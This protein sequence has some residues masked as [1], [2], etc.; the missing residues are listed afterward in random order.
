MTKRILNSVFILGVLIF[1]VGIFG[2]S[3]SKTENEAARSEELGLSLLSEEETVDIVKDGSSDYVILFSQGDTM[4][5]DTELA[6]ELSTLIRR[7]YGVTVRYKPD[8]STDESECEILLGLTTRQLSRDLAEAIDGIG[9]EGEYVWVIAERDGKLAFLANSS[10]AFE[11]GKEEFLSYLTED[12]FS[13][14]RGLFS[15]GHITLDEIEAENAA[16]REKELERLK[17]INAENFSEELFGKASYKP[18]IA[19]NGAHYV[20]SPYDKPWFYPTVGQHPRYL[21][22]G[23]NIDRIKEML[24]D[25]T[26]ANL[27]KAFWELANAGEDEHFFGVFPEVKGKTGT[28]R[29]DSRILAIIDAK[30]LAY[31]ITG[32]E[33][34]A[35][36]AI[37]SI[38]NAALT[39]KFTTDIHGD[40][41]HGPSHVMV[42]MAAVYDWCYDVLTE[43]DKWQMIYCVATKLAAGL[44][45]GMQYPPSGMN[46]VCGHG[47]GPQFVRDWMTVAMV[48]ADEVPDWWEFVG[49]RYFEE[50]L[51]VAN[52]QFENGWVSQGTAIYGQ[53]KI[54]AQAWAAYLI[55]TSV[56]ENC[57][58]EDARLTMYYEM[59]HIASNDMYFQTGDGSRNSVGS[60][61]GF[62]EYFVVA[63]LYNDP[64]IY[65]H[66]RRYSKDHTVFFFEEAGYD[67]ILT[68]TPAFQLCFTS[69]VDY[70]G[71]DARDGVDVIQY[72]ADPAGQMTVREAWDDE[73]SITVFMKIGNET[74]SNHDVNDHGTF[75]IYYKGLL[76]ATS[77]AYNGYGMPSH[78]YYHQATIAH[79]GLLIFNPA[80][81]DAEPDY[82][83]TLPVT[84]RL[85]NASRYYYSGSQD[86]RPQPDTIEKWTNGQ[87]DMAETLGA[88]WGYYDDGA[89]K[90][91]YIA[92]DLT[93]A[94]NS[95]TVD[96]VGRRMLTLYTGDA[97]FP[98]LFITYDQITSDSESFPKSW[99]LHV[100]KEP[101]VDF[102]KKTATVIN[103]DGKMY[104]HSVFG[105]DEL[106]SIGGE[107]RAYWFNG[108]TDENG[109]YVEGKNCY[110]DYNTSDNYKNIWGRIELRSSGRKHNDMLTLMA[111]TDADNE[112]EFT[113]TPVESDSVY[114]VSA[115]NTV[116][117]F[118]KPTQNQYG[119]FSFTTEGRGMLTYYVSGIDAG[120]WRVIVDGVSVAYSYA[121]E[122]ECFM[123]FTAPA[124]EVKLV[125]GNDV[126][127][128][129]GGKIQYSTGGASL[130]SD[131]PYHYRNWET[132]IL[133]TN[134]KRGNDV[135]LGWYTT[136]TY[137]EGTRWTEIP[138]G[139]RG[140]VKLYAKW[141]SNFT[142]E[143]YTLTELDHYESRRD[144]NGITYNGLQKEG[145]SFVT[146]TDKNGVNY[147][148]WREGTQDSLICQ[149]SSS[150]NFANMSAEDG[151]VSFTFKLSLDEGSSVMS[152]HIR[153]IAKV[154]VNGAPISSTAAVFLEFAS[155]GKVVT[156]SGVRIATLST[157]EITELR[158]V[159]DFKKGEFRYYNEY[160]ELIETSPLV[161]PASTKAANAEEFRKCLTEYVWYWYGG[162]SSGIADAATRIYGIRVQEGDE[163]SGKE[164]VQ[165]EGIKY[166]TGGAR[167]PDDAPRDFIEGADTPLPSLKLD[168]YVFDGWYT[169]PTFDEGTRVAFAPAGTEGLFEV[170]AKWN[171]VFLD[172]DWTEKVIDVGNKPTLIDGV[173][174]AGN[175]HPGVSYK[176]ALG[177][178]GKRYLLWT[179]GPKDPLIVHENALTN[180]S[181][182]TNTSISYTVKLGAH[183]DAFIP[184]F[185]F[186]IIAKKDV[187]GADVTTHFTFAYVENG[188]VYITNNLNGVSKA[189]DALESGKITTV[190]IV[191]DFAEGTISAYNAFGMAIETVSFTAPAASGAAT[192][193]E[194]K[195]CFRSYLYYTR[196]GSAKD[197]ALRYYGLRIEEG[198][199]FELAEGEEPPKS[200]E[201]IYALDG[202]KLPTGAPSE[203]DPEFGTK[204][205][206]P[207]KDGFEFL[208]WYNEDGQKV[209]T[210]GE[211]AE[212]PILVTARWTKI[213][214]S[215][216]FE[217]SDFDVTD[218]KDNINYNEVMLRV[219]ADGTAL[220]TVTDDDDNKFIRYS[221]L[222][223]DALLCVQNDSYNLTHMSSDFLSMKMDIIPIEGE[224]LTRVLIKIATSG[225]THG[226]LAIASLD[227]DT[228]D[229][230]LDGSSKV[231][232]N[233]KENKATVRI[234]I[235]F[236]MGTASALDAD[237]NVLDS[238]ALTVPSNNVSSL[239]EW[240][241]VAKNYLLYT[242]LMNSYSSS[243]QTSYI[244]FDNILIAEG[245]VFASDDKDAAE[246]YEIGY[247]PNGA[248]LPE[249]LPTEYDPENGTPLPIL[250][251]EGF[252]FDG[253]YTTS[254]YAS[255]SKV[256][257]VGLGCVGKINVFAKWLTLY[258]ESDFDSTDFDVDETTELYSDG[259]FAFR[260][261]AAGSKLK[262]EVD[263]SG[264]KYLKFSVLDKDALVVV[265]N[266][267]NNLTN[268]SDDCLSMQ[269]DFSAIGD[270]NVLAA[271]IKIATSGGAHGQL[272]LASVDPATGD[273][274]LKGGS[275]AIANIKN[276]MARVRLVINFVFSTV[277]A[278]DE[279]GEVIDTVSLVPPVNSVATLDEWR[280][281][282]KNYLLYL[283]M[284]NTNADKT[285]HATLGCDN[286]RV[287]EGNIFE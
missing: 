215:E 166:N 200:N 58:T 118:T 246:S 202:G 172:V 278:Y 71:E 254:G 122:S 5:S 270:D 69:A 68:M 149:T 271:D 130:P 276:G 112:K 234:L 146:K 87:Y 94:Y 96:F 242:Y 10:A 247:Y 95:A 98:A 48:F 27:S 106:L 113:Y 230:K 63:A 143:D 226:Q 131:A 140:L 218:T 165:T 119:S 219:V 188:T 30:A 177:E 88:A 91:A 81:A 136:P 7:T 59:S 174:Y 115:L 40:V 279:D 267:Q 253:W 185:D 156:P 170:F 286:F 191:I 243:G 161:P 249:N 38:K 97:D 145:S 18:L 102:D 85:K 196:I 90:F 14:P 268:M 238:V 158:L 244:G 155:D 86:M 56:G 285:T 39:L 13:V 50:Y 123:T 250:E 78:Y 35:M 24:D 257:S 133:P 217:E 236:K 9:E 73:D 245:N 216:D 283:Y 3:L 49:G 36:E 162:T 208:G 256:E 182:M 139:T 54:H 184:N 52:L 64:V 104:V 152:S 176:T 280:R 203:Y 169:T 107:G 47:T 1:F 232:A 44:E 11:R 53:L 15:I 197:G 235:D 82:D 8:A 150:K 117:V 75:Q 141:F 265:Q 142:D 100:I 92:G 159:I 116:A 83:P 22:N 231:I 51:P 28:Y 89:P 187:N 151:C 46:P 76:A 164:I 77:G 252:V 262:T 229:I 105:A 221:I 222:K 110:D 127:G 138:E 62:S 179:V 125:P 31:L 194:W 84:R 41:Y 228:G 259:G 67:T 255:N 237:A 6:S 168:G 20:H 25:P 93:N 272:A 101:E 4:M 57:L 55:K 261:T 264:N 37:I 223:N 284:M 224:L 29:Y 199:A 153:L 74:M 277:S 120:T 241:R 220:K 163:F 192:P 281:V 111:I 121:D 144:V 42:T 189:V 43:T 129:N 201:I 204:L 99:L 213:F 263:E 251:K 260:V 128:A 109:N 148:E 2:F 16:N 70:N 225:G 173:N 190:R 258:A 34:Y 274:K 239:D 287:V 23:G 126:I 209:Y 154:D 19:E 206:T 79:N 266:D 181:T 137:D 33:L 233:V 32:D 193:L 80:F 21:L 12:G 195:Q 282:A 183:A 61:V 212:T 114:G 186:R 248:S 103:G 124:G 72:F 205:P 157:D 108:Y 198:N 17:E 175:N 45:T 160:Y 65:A 178:D 26:Y 214:A 135:F 210:V 132:T 60:K 211:G 134:V 275:V 207:V 66:A 180:I 240:K 171:Q 167:L 273:V 227:P 269:L 147:L